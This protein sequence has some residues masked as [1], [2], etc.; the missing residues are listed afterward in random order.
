MIKE[1]YDCSHRA[2]PLTS[3]GVGVNK[4][5]RSTLRHVGGR[6]GL[7][8]VLCLS[9]IDLSSGPC[10]TR[11]LELEA[12]ARTSRLVVLV[13]RGPRSSLSPVPPLLNPFGPGQSREGAHAAR[14]TFTSISNCV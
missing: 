9:A 12:L 7:L 14:Q 10:S 3:V 5:P 2:A 4:A 11:L 8:V 1:L 13:V 6:H